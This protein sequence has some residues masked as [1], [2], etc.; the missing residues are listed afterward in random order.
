[1]SKKTPWFISSD[2]SGDLSLT[3]KSL[4]LGVVPVGITIA[5]LYGYSVEEHDIV[6]LINNLFAMA[7]TAGVIVGLGRK[8]WF[9]F[10]K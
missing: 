9:S 8:I 3:I 6:E 1:M 5:G 2:N 7:A 10:H 4:L